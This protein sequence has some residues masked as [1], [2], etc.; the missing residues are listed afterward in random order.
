MARLP[1]RALAVV[2]LLGGLSLPASGFEQ[3]EGCFVAE[4][5]CPGL[6]SIRQNRNPG[7]VATEAGATYRL[8]GANRPQPSHYQIDVPGADPNGRWVEVDC[9][10]IVTTCELAGGEQE[11]PSGPSEGGSHAD[12]LLAASWQPAFCEIKERQKPECL[13]QEGRFDADHFALHGLWPQPNGLFYCGLPPGTAGAAWQDLPAL[14]LSK[15]TRDALD[16]VMPGTRSFLHR[17]EWAKHGTCY[18]DTPEEYYLESLQ[19][20]DDLNAS[21]VRDLFQANLGSELT[22]SQIREAFDAAFGPGAGERVHISCNRDGGVALIG[23]L[24]VALRGEIKETTTLA[25]LIQAAAPN[26]GGC[27]AGLVDVA[28]FQF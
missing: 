22:A 12:N 17:H 20:M 28:G 4:Q 27:Q 24:R 9:G 13:N 3:L 16:R 10:R 14:E 15:G 8:F 6:A 25:E 7:N 21:A 19:L 1:L 5:V 11:D 26:G 18:S 23:E 2:A